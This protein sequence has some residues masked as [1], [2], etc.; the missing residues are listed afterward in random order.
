MELL[1]FGR[2]SLKRLDIKEIIIGQYWIL[3]RKS[4]YA[5]IKASEK[6]YEIKAS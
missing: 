5:P 4:D 3:R 1:N 6:Q 2:S